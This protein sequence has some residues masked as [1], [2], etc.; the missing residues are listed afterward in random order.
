MKRCSCLT[1]ACLLAMASMARAG[2]LINDDFQ[3]GQG[4]WTGTG[5]ARVDVGG[6]QYWFGGTSGMMGNPTKSAGGHATRF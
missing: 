5:W 2:F 4:A 6:G 3:T 1:V